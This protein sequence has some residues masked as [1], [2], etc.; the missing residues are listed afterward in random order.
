M[1]NQSFPL[2][3]L[4]LLILRSKGRVSECLRGNKS[5]SCRRERS[6][7]NRS[8]NVSLAGGKEAREDQRLLTIPSS[9]L[10]RRLQSREAEQVVHPSRPLVTR[11][12]LST[13]AQ[14]LA[15]DQRSVAVKVPRRANKL[16]L[17][18]RTL[19]SAR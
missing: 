5:G 1:P 15:P 2:C 13:G 3:R 6:R 8:K 16:T 10:V 4:A 9:L 12:N 19:P 7:T 11:I 17:F 18:L 14:S